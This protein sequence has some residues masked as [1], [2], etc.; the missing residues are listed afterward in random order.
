[1]DQARKHRRRSPDD[2]QRVAEQRR[3]AAHT[4]S[5]R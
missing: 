1:V 2:L 3:T 4:G 5:R